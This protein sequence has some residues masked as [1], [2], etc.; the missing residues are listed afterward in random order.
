MLSTER[1]LSPGDLAVLLDHPDLLLVDVCKPEV[2]AAGHLPGAVHVDY[3]DLVRAA[4]PVGGLLPEP[5]DLAALVR[6]LA[7]TPKSLVVAYD[8]A[9]GGRAARLLWTLYALGYEHLALLDGGRAAWLEDGHALRTETSVREADDVAVP[10]APVRAVADSDWVARHLDDPDVIFL[11]T[12]SPAEF[13]GQD[14]RAARGG[15]I[16][17][18]INVDWTLSMRTDHHHA[19]RPL[20]ELREL[21]ES[22]GVRREAEVV[23][24]CQTHHRSSHTFWVLRHIGHERVRGYPG[25]WSE[26]GNREDLP[27]E[28]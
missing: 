7:L 25:A 9:A 5:A 19:L 27:V 15:H 24:Y 22:A 1:V 26:W 16:P 11:D 13:S 23:V 18:A 14:R 20:T 6:R 17:G 8:D 2:H 3:S 10:T 28:I 21:Y 4:P 12:R